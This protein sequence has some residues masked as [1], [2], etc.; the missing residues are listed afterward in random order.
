M[1]NIAAET[2]TVVYKVALH[3]LVESRAVNVDLT[4]YNRLFPGSKVYK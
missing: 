1:A 2:D 3:D 4:M